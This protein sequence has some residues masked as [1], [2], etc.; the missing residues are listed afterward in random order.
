MTV[1]IRLDLLEREIATA[2]VRELGRGGML[3]DDSDD[4][5]DNDVRLVSAIYV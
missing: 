5:S 4:G 2:L 3:I 1:N